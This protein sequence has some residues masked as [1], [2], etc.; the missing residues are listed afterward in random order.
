[1]RYAVANFVIPHEYGE[2]DDEN[3]ALRRLIELLFH[4]DNNPRF[5]K[6]ELEKTRQAVGK[7][8]SFPT[9]DEAISEA[10][11]QRLLGAPGDFWVVRHNA[12]KP[13]NLWG[14]KELFEVGTCL[15]GSV[16]DFYLLYLAG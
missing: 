10:V 12:S 6:I 16:G 1:M 2:F 14:G 15:S 9:I 5:Y 4:D 3:A 11:N 8:E 7:W 13:F